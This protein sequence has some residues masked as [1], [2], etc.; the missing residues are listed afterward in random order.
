MWLVHVNGREVRQGSGAGGGSGFV[1]LKYEQVFAEAAVPGGEDAGGM[2][3][4]V[5]RAIVVGDGWGG[6]SR[7]FN[8]ESF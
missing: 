2:L 1:D 6:W 4:D 7:S 5:E 3:S 8:L